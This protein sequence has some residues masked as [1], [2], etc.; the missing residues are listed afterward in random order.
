MPLQTK[1]RL[2][3]GVLMVL[4]FAWTG[5]QALEF[6][7]LASYMPLGMSGLGVVL[8]VIAVATDVLNWKRQGLVASVDVPETAALHGAEEMELKIRQGEVEVGG[9]DTPTDPR[10]IAL[11]SG[12]MF[13]WILGYVFLIWLV[14]IVAASAVFLIAYLR[15]VARSSWRLPL[16]GT[17]VI[18]SGMWILRTLLNLRW[19]DYLLQDLLPFLGA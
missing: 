3:V 5:W 6:A 11:R 13:A 19:P 2:T 8:G 7:R 10:R 15:F 17:A 14:G 18:L 16:L 1:M 9:P 4:L 12:A